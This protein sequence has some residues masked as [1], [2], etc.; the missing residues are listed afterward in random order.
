MMILLSSVHVMRSTDRFY[1]VKSIA[2]T[3]HPIKKKMNAA[4]ST[5]GPCHWEMAAQPGAALTGMG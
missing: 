2:D 1:K 5:A 4:P 3:G